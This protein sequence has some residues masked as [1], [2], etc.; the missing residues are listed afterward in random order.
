MEKYRKSKR[1]WE[2]GP[3]EMNE[4]AFVMWQVHGLL[5]FQTC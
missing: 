2:M 4:F 5:D 3:I 1:N